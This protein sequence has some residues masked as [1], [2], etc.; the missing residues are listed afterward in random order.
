MSGRQ[1]VAILLG[2]LLAIVAG[3]WLD[4]L[5]R[6]AFVAAQPAALVTTGTLEGRGLVETVKNILSLRQRVAEL[7]AENTSLKAQIVSLQEEQQVTE[8]ASRAIA[9]VPGQF[10]ASV[11]A[12]RVVSRSPSR[13]A[14][15]ILVNRGERDGVRVGQPVFDA[16][17]LAGLV[18]EVSAATS[19]VSLLSNP[20]LQIPVTFQETRAQG[21]LRGGLAGLTIT[22][23]PSDAAITP[24]EP[25]VTSA[26]GEVVRPGIPVGV[27]D[28][29]LSK[30]SEVLQRVLLRSPVEFHRLEFVAIDTDTWSEP[31]RD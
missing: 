30:D 5:R 8:L 9:Q 24:G 16:G 12:A 27:A 14:D 13:L 6:A 29:I 4:P 10:Q 23:I 18:T 2:T 22:D 15:G 31:G 20:S 19:Q 21:L 7:E 25:V 17:F 28:Q 3:P 1:V 26:L 11:I